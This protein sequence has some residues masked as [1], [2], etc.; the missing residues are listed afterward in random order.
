MWI[1]FPAV[2]ALTRLPLS[3]CDCLSDETLYQPTRYFHSE[4]S[5]ADTSIAKKQ[6]KKK[7]DINSMVCY[8]DLQR[9]KGLKSDLRKCYARGPKKQVLHKISMG[10]EVVLS[11]FFKVARIVVYDWLCTISRAAD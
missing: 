7:S 9:V 2:L 11:V 1:Q 3:L 10:P 4:H 8:D 6:T 5:A